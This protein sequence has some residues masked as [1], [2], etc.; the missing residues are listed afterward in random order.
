MEVRPKKE[1]GGL[2]TDEDSGR[3]KSGQC[4]ARHFNT[5][6]GRSQLFSFSL[7]K[8]GGPEGRLMVTKEPST[9]GLGK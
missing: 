2:T 5:H 7:G 8:G 3:G 6:S 1:A 9:S 4:P